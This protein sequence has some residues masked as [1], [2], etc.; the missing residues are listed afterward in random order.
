MSDTTNDAL[1]GKTLSQSSLLAYEKYHQALGQD[2]SAVSQ[3][4]TLVWPQQLFLKL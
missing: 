4:H 1:Y 3:I 2:I